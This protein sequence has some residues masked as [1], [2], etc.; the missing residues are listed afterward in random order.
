M[1]TLP[2][3]TQYMPV[4]TVKTLAQ[5]TALGLPASAVG[6]ASAPIFVPPGQD[7][8]GTINSWS[9]NSISNNP[10]WFAITWALPSNNFKVADGP[11][12][13][14]YGN[15]EYGATGQ[16]SG[17]FIDGTMTGMG[18]VLHLGTNNPINTQDIQS[19]V[20]AVA[21]GGTVTVVQVHYP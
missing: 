8:Q 6:T 14:A 11:I 9:G 3:G 10:Y 12:Y 13:D 4:T 18:D 5:A 19:G 21:N 2:D 17:Q 16:A 7:P 15:F 20:N 1:V